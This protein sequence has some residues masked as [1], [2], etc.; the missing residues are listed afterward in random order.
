VLHWHGETFDLPNGS[1][2]ISK[3][4]AC[5]NQG[6]LYQEKVLGLQFHMEFTEKNTEVML[7]NCSSDLQEGKYIQ[8]E[9]GIRTQ[10]AY[11]SPA[12]Q[13]LFGI[14]DALSKNSA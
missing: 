9:A 14:L 12:K 6:F 13:A 1:F 11:I 7:S 8:T 3:S 10:T 2:R 5:L 4:E